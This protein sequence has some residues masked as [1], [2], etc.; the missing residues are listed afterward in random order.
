MGCM[1]EF[2]SNQFIKC[3]VHLQIITID[4]VENLSKPQCIINNRFAAFRNCI[5][6]P[7]DQFKIINSI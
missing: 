1:V 6:T 3:N 7:P 4:L 5:F 2:Q